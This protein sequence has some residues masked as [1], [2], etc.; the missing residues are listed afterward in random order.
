MAR[1]YV[2]RLTTVSQLAQWSSAKPLLTPSL[3][4]LRPTINAQ[5]LLTFNSHPHQQHQAQSTTAVPP[6]PSST[7]FF[8]QG[9]ATTATT[10]TTT[11]ST[12]PGNF[13][14]LFTVHSDAVGKAAAAAAANTKHLKHSSTGATA[15]AQAAST[16]G[17]N[18]LDNAQPDDKENGAAPDCFQFVAHAAWHPKNRNARQRQSEDKIPYWKRSKVGKVDAGED[19]F[20][21]T[22]TPYGMALG[23]ADGVGGWA[24]AGVDPAI[25]SWTLMNNAAGIAKKSEELPPIHALQILDTAFHQLRRGGKVAAGSSTAC[26]LNLCKTTGEMTSV[27]LGDS[28][29][30]LIRDQKIVYESPSQQHYFNCPYQLTVVPD[31]YPDRESFVTD[32]P[33]DADQKTFFLKDNDIILLATDGYFDN[34]YPQETLALINNGMGNVLRAERDDFSDDQVA[35]AV[36]TLAKTLTD[37]ARRFSLDP[38]RLSP[39]ARDARAH[40]SNYRGGKIDDITCV[41]TLVR[42][43]KRSDNNNS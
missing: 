17:G 26:I 39:W 2:Q 37:A 34:V 33:K 35:D 5:R 11:S 43:L 27:N 24:D 12:Q 30:V 38:K 9:H 41:V 22:N 42:G 20:F 13:E 3:T 16:T 15:A 40:G 31:T 28:A 14:R 1:Q 32:M 21:H 25:F 7:S 10:S 19:A 36:R 23:V 29:F 4:Y 8:D 18:T 6:S